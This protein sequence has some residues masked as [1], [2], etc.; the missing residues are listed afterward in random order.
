MLGVAPFPSPLRTRP[1]SPP[2][3]LSGPGPIAGEGT[4]EG[5]P[6]RLRSTVSG[7]LAPFHW[8]VTDSTRENLAMRTLPR[9]TSVWSGRA[10]AWALFVVG[11]VFCLSLAPAPR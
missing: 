4:G 10:K 6:V 8:A 2:F 5:D 3:R 11:V 7:E 1:P 9:S